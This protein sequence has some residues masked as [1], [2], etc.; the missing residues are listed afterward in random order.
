V[1][2]I[3]I[4]IATCFCLTSL[5]FAEPRPPAVR[6][7]LDQA[8]EIQGYPCD[9]GYA[10]FFEEGGGLHSCR[11]S[12]EASFGDARASA[13]SWLYLRSDGKP[14]SAILRHDTRIDG[15]TCQGSAMGLEGISTAFYPNGRLKACWLAADE[16]IEGV[17]CARGGFFKDLGGGGSTTEFYENGS[18]RGCK[19]SRAA[20]IRDQGFSSGARVVVDRSGRIQAAPAKR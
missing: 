20:T 1:L 2:R 12:R 6:K 17:P 15:H 18:L 11:L 9:K 4:W 19:L 5:A 3:A 16:E 8:T 10:W 7:H 13:G 14:A